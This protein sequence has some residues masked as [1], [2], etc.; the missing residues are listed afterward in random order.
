MLTKALQPTV[1]THLGYKEAST[2]R[3]LEKFMRDLYSHMRCIFLTTRT[4]EERLALLPR[5]SRLG[6]LS[7]FLPAALGE[8]GF[9]LLATLKAALDPLGILNPG[10]LGLPDPFGPVAWP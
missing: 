9:A 1:A 2:S 5:Q 10:K 6:N 3:R 8:G 4:L 7:R